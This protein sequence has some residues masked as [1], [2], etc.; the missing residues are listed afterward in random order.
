MPEGDTIFRAAHTLAQAIE[1]ATVTGFASRVGQVR[2]RLP[3]RL[4]GQRVAKVEARGKHLL[5]WFTPSD[6]ALHTH[7]RMNGSWHLY[8]AGERWRKDAHLARAVIETDGW[9]AVCF[10]APVCQL[11]T[12]RE[13][14]Q[15][16]SIAALGPD[17][18][19]QQTDLVEARRRL[20][21]RGEWTV[22][23]ALLDQR[24]LAGVGNVYKCE[25]LF[26]HG[27][28]PWTPV[29]AVPPETRDALLATA[30]RLLK[31]NVAPGGPPGRTTTA[32]HDGAGRLYV[33]G[34]ARR[35]CPRCA[36]PISRE[37]QGE[38][39]RPTYWCR[40]CQGPGPVQQASA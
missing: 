28:D 32:P 29:A 13:V 34:R 5:I 7:M 17:A 9:Q 35:P 24:V 2:A 21:A 18:L 23:E 25:V 36:T 39:A 8:R 3:N 1:G 20:D 10:S 37:R 38:Q 11:L 19:A 22:A 15:H 40:R 16:P 14:D 26:I 4:V 6:L 33:Y 30:E 31:A 27:V 12:R